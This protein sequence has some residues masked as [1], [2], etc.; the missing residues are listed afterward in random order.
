MFNQMKTPT[1]LCF[2]AAIGVAFAEDA[3]PPRLT[4]LFTAKVTAGPGIELGTLPAGD[5]IAYPI[6]GGTFTGPRGLNGTIAPV[7]AD[8]STE[9]PEKLFSP[10]GVSILQTSDG[11]NILFR[12][13]GFQLGKYVYGSATFQTG[14]K[15]YT[16]LNTAVTV[17]RALVETGG[18]GA[19]VGLE[20]FQVS[21]LLVGRMILLSLN[22][23]LNLGG[24]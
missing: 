12:D 16:W 19:A 20:V 9:T 21:Y 8:F 22:T 23:D 3:D 10:E 11:A 4:R 6:T 18:T 13:S 5:R 7:G 17:S 24:W 1:L 14:A 2:S 15:N